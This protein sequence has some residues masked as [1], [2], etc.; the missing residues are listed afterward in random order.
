MCVHL[1]KVLTVLLFTVLY[2]P[3]TSGIGSVFLVICSVV[4]VVFGLVRV[5]P[6]V[7][8]SSEITVNRTCCFVL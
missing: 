5:V 2:L 3:E 4:V 6:G 7:A 8:T 1:S